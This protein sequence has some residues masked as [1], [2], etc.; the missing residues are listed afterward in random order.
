MWYLAVI[1]LGL[2]IGS[3]LNAAI[4]RL[5][6][7]QSVL[8]GRSKC[9]RCEEP[10]RPMDLVPILSFFILRGRCRTCH[11]SIS[12]QYPL[13]E[14]VTAL[15]FFLFYLKH[16]QLWFGADALSSVSGMYTLLS[17]WIF[18]PF[19]IVLFVYD[20]RYMILPDQFS[21]PAI[22]LAVLMNLWIGMPAVELILGAL[23]LGGFFY[24]QFVLSRGTWV[25]GGDIRMGVLMGALLG[26][27]QGLVALFIAYAIGAIFGIGLLIFKR[28]D[29]KTPIPFG[30]FLTLAT[31]CLLFFGKAP[32]QWY[33]S[34]FV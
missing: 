34:F 9:L 15:L 21:I 26:L 33:L 31:L 11:S 18:I 1:V 3:F 5:H 12:W 13:V 24:V 29:R 7:G 14:L 20:L 27:T 8:R 6:E 19:L 25:G 4:F 22:I 28:V 32:L 16:Q 30:T 10:I 2:C 23:I 17:H